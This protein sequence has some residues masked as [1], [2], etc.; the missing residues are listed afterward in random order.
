MCVFQSSMSDKMGSENALF[1]CINCEKD[2]S[3][4]V[5][6][7]DNYYGYYEDM[8]DNMQDTQANMYI[9]MAILCIILTRMSLILAMITTGKRAMAN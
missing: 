9:F 6:G 2:F 7:S 4:R 5:M 8:Y 3:A 1:E